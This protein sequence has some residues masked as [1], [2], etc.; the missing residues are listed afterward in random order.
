MVGGVP[1][2]AGGGGGGGGPP[3]APTQQGFVCAGGGADPSTEDGSDLQVFTP[4][5]VHLLLRKV[6]GYFPHHNDGTYL[7]GG[8]PDNATWKFCWRQLAAQSASWYSTPPGKVGR[9][10]TAV[11]AAEW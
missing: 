8:V 2:T 5:R 10:F 6:Y 11:R 4:E 3:T 7:T 1:G 9:R